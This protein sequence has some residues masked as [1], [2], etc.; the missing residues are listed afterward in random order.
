[1]PGAVAQCE[2]TFTVVG[3]SS[4]VYL[5]TMN[6][7]HE[8]FCFE[9]INVHVFCVR[10]TWSPNT[11]RPNLLLAGNSASRIIKAF[12]KTLR[13]FC[14]WNANLTVWLVDTRSVTTN[15]LD[16]A[17][18]E[19]GYCEHPA[20][21]SRFFFSERNTSDWYLIWKY[22]YNEFTVCNEHIFMNYV[23]RCKEDPMYQKT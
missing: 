1:M 18:N 21:T 6:L 20:I 2:Q 11:N 5:I 19:F 10:T 13:L 3:E 23:A 7:R 16:P 22:G 9:L 14:G 17:Y 15:R 12:H 8:V 4:C